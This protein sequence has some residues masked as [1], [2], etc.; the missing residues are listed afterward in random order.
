VECRNLS[1]KR[2]VRI[3]HAAMHRAVQYPRLKS[4]LSV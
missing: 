2:S 1:E 3:F 4:R